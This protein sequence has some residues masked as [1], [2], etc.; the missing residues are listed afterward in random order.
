M[1]SLIIYILMFINIEI[2][3]GLLLRVT[4]KAKD[5]VGGSLA[6]IGMGVIGFLLLMAIVELLKML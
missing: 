4:Y 1:A 2:T 3:L 6:I 5:M